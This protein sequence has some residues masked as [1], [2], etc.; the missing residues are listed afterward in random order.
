MCRMLLF[1]AAYVVAIVRDPRKRI[2]SAYR[3]GL[4]AVGQTSEERS[5]ML[6]NVRTLKD[7]VKWP[8]IASCQVKMF[9]GFPCAKAM[10]VTDSMTNDAIDIMSKAAFIGLTDHWNDT[11]CLFHSMFGENI[12][13]AEL[14]NLRSAHDLHDISSSSTRLKSNAVLSKQDDPH[15]WRLYQASKRRF[16]ELQL[17]YGVPH[18]SVDTLD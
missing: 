5:S 7:F 10:E 17:K 11:I 1:S 2:L 12:T 6:A 15:D 18:L 9:L 3:Y 4:H 13:V 8:G 16:I 14:E